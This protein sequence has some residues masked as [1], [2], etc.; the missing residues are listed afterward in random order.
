MHTTRKALPLIAASM[1]IALVTGCS[2]TSSTGA[3]NSSSATKL[4]TSAQ[5]V[6]QAVSYQFP[7]NGQL[8]GNPGQS[9]VVSL[10]ADLLAVAVTDAKTVLVKSFTVS[11]YTLSTPTLCAFDVIVKY[12]R[13]DARALILAY[14]RANNGVPVRASVTD[15][16]LVAGAVVDGGGSDYAQQITTFNAK[17]PQPG[18]YTNTSGTMF[19]T[20]IGCSTSPSGDMGNTGLTGTKLTFAGSTNTAFEAF[21]RV[22]AMAGRIVSIGGNTINGWTRDANGR[23]ITS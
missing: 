23:W 18:I 7:I 11:P 8:P 17:D 20:V 10:P 1:G 2:S 5:T 9:I 6:T 12:T 16:Q 4:S 22:V 19:R 15:D 13:P 3:P 14:E 21:V